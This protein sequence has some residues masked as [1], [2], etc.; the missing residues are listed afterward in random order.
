MGEKARRRAEFLARH[1]FCCFC[2]GFEPATTFDHQPPRALFD[3][4]EVPEGFLFPACERCNASSRLDEQVSAFVSLLNSS[5]SDEALA[6][7]RRLRTGIENNQ[8]ELLPRVDLSATEKRR[9]LRRFGIERG[10]GAFLDD[11]PIV[12]LPQQAVTA[13]ERHFR[14]LALAL[15]YREMKFIAPEDSLV[16]ATVIPNANFMETGD[17]KELAGIFTFLRAS[18]LRR[19]DISRQFAYRCDIGVERKLFGA[20]VKFHVAVMGIVA[21][22]LDRAII[23]PEENSEWCDLS[24]QVV[25]GTR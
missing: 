8:P 18:T 20:L 17:L 13:M 21:V 23:G 12:A 6:R 9:T 11:L 10:P 24:G 2:G 5:E 14:K 19:R 3:R 22:C 7:F 25:I 4:R 1:P 15:F 16:C